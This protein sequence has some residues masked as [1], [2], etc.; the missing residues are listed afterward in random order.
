[1]R[2][3]SCRVCG[4]ALYFENSLCLSCGTALAYSRDEHD[5][6]PL[7][8]GQYVD[9]QGYIWHVCRNLDLSGCTWLATVEGGLCF[10]CE[11]T[12]TRPSD[13]DVE[14]LAQFPIAEAAKR[15]L[16]VELDALHLPVTPRR[17]DPEHGVCFDLL[18]SVSEKV[19]IGHEDGVITI[20]LAEGDDVRRVRMQKEL[21]EAYRTMLGHF[22]HEI[23]HYY[24][25]LLVQGDLIG[26]AR[27]LFGDE[28]ASYE[29]ALDR[30][31]SQG[32]PAD[33]QASYIS[34]YATM[35]PFEDFA[36]TF[37]HYLHIYDSVSTARAYG[38]TT[39]DPDAFT[40]FADLVRGVW[41]PLSTALNQMNR[42]LGRHDLYPFALSEPVLTKLEFVASLMPSH[43]PTG[44]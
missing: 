2:S 12:R 3:Y 29:E 30:H 17:Q 25:D 31:Y 21:G 38:L 6:V 5:I 28:T 1:M 24:E 35:H 18:S 22:R 33:W 7:T 34:T 26:Q 32:P 36:E 15:H 39:V 44:A 13:A 27:E 41:V 19:M 8:D 40:S 43:S 37:A 11:L 4:N 42:S 9:A 10:S 16:I 14:G 20:D 23:G